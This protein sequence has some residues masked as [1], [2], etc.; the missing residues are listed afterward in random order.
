MF[1]SKGMKLEKGTKVSTVLT[2]ED[3]LR[4]I[5]RQGFFKPSIPQTLQPRS[6]DLVKKTDFPCNE[7]Q[8]FFFE[9]FFKEFDFYKFFKFEHQ[10]QFLITFHVHSVSTNQPCDKP[11]QELMICILLFGCI[12]FSE[13]ISLLNYKGK[14]GKSKQVSDSQAI[15]SKCHFTGISI[16]IFK[17]GQTNFYWRNFFVAA[18]P[19]KQEISSLIRLS[20][21]LVSLNADP[22]TPNA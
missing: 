21:N 12:T 6:L 5:C 13:V 9:L 3:V 15:Y 7:N 19:T 14:K 22:T 16:L 10:R 2:D 20:K 1:P 8:F 4:N 11:E 17:M 18:M